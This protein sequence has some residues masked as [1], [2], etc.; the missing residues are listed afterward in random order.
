MRHLLAR[1][2]TL[3]LLMAATACGS[4]H[5]GS[6]L[7]GDL[8]TPAPTLPPPGLFCPD[9]AAQGTS[10]RVTNA[11]GYSIAAVE[12]GTG[13]NVVVLA[14]QAAGDLCQWLPYALELKGLGYRAIALSFAGSGGSTYITD[15]FTYVD[16]LRAVVDHARG[17]G[18]AKIVLLGASAGGT[19]ALAGG[20]EIKPPVDG[21][22]ALSAPSL[23]NGLQGITS[24]GQLTMPTLVIAAEDD[25]SFPIA[26][27][28]IGEAVPAGLGT[29]MILPGYEHGV[30]LT[31]PGATSGTKVRAAIVRFLADRFS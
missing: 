4:D 26:A 31:D 22:I 5:T 13:P 8:T 16:D 24:A 17:T 14:H 15:A 1:A 30:G 25:E 6:A 19:A 11:E 18:A 12:V 21:V 27:L 23:Y 3:A 29:T 10:F 28:G 7:P 9:N 2:V 20:A